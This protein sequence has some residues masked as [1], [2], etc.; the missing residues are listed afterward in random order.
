MDVGLLAVNQLSWN[1]YVL[2]FDSKIKFLG[3]RNLQVK[4]LGSE[5]TVVAIV[6]AD[7]YLIVLSRLLADKHTM[8]KT[9]TSIS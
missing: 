8:R 2:D 5:V 1:L 6:K 4:E 7:S 3:G 9:I